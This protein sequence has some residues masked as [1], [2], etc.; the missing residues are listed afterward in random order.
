M[1]RAR[2]SL[3]DPW[4]LA[5][6]HLAKPRAFSVREPRGIIHAAIA[7]PP[8]TPLPRDFANV[9]HSFAKAGVDAPEL[10][11]AM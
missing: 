2:R 6:R 7:K 4:T 1:H 5:A 9:A 8:A 3:R 10:F 11:E